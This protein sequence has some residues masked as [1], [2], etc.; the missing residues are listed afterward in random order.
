LLLAGGHIIL[1]GQV[2]EAGHHEVYPGTLTMLPGDRI[3]CTWDYYQAG[4]VPQGRALMYTISDDGGISWSENHL[5][6]DPD[7]PPDPSIDV[8]QHLGTLRHSILPLE[9]G[10]WL[11]PLTQENDL[12]PHQFPGVKIYDPETG[13]LVTDPSLSPGMFSDFV[14]CALCRSKCIFSSP[15]SCD[16]RGG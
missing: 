6:F 5:I 3:L 16:R 13:A 14:E 9:D 4:N 10:R 8:N 12:G 1:Y 11:L 15:L 2:P 7:T